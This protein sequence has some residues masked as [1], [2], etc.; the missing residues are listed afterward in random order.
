MS[1]FR[2]LH[3]LQSISWL[4]FLAVLFLQ[5]QADAQVDKT[6]VSV[7]D[8]MF[9]ELEKM[10]DQGNL[11]DSVRDYATIVYEKADSL[12]KPIIAFKSK[13]YLG[14]INARTG[15]NKI[16]LNDFQEALLILEEVPDSFPKV[17]HQGHIFNNM[18]NISGMLQEFSTA[19]GYLSKALKIFEALDHKSKVEVVKMNMGKV[20]AEMNQH[21][22]AI[23]YFKARQNNFLALGDSFHYT[24]S[25]INLANSFRSIDELDSAKHYYE[26]A[27]HFLQKFPHPYSSAFLNESLSFFHEEKGNLLLAIEYLDKVRKAAGQMSI[28]EM[29]MEAHQR[30]SELH[31]A[32][33]QD[34]AAYHAF[35]RY[36]E[37]KK[38]IIDSERE[39]K[40]ARLKA[41]HAYLQEEESLRLSQI[42]KKLE[43][44]AQLNKQLVFIFTLLAV[45]FLI[46]VVVFL[47]HKSRKAKHKAMLD[48]EQKNKAIEEQQKKLKKQA[49][50][51]EEAGTL[52]NKLFSIIAHDLRTPVNSLITMLEMIESKQIGEEE[53]PIF[54]AQLNKDV[55]YT[56][57]FLDNLL[58]WSRQQ[59]QNH[60]PQF[61]QHLLY[62]VVE[63]VINLLQLQANEKKVALAIEVSKTHACFADKEMM[64]LV[65]RNL[66]ANALKFSHKGEKVLVRSTE[67][68]DGYL[69][70]EVIDEGVGIPKEDLPKIFGKQFFTTTGTAAEKGTGL[71][72]KLCQDFIAKNKG[73]MGVESEV[74]KGSTF[75]FVVPQTQT[76]S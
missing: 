63:D 18:A 72:L 3:A 24:M 29:E 71:G 66:V 44:E 7:I 39:L 22:S 73:K 59:M 51:L 14:I 16:A 64:R 56:Y 48:L 52:K 42:E 28:V 38:E 25:V 45:A 1:S 41:E 74:G 62:P 27:A 50:V 23:H 6:E 47:L 33:G 36:T 13:K 17:E 30:L 2:P 61:S 70:V 57:G 9:L 15:L 8:S 10:V 58:N 26:E 60:E 35:R 75:Y 49:E 32:V 69:K 67:L 54:I 31:Q 37:L 19:L 43:N 12:E 5:K 76:T 46:A 4:L 53:L 21:D 68:D 34:E 65:I 11:G 40:V 20:Y 55:G